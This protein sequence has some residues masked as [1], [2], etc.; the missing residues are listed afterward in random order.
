MWTLT[1]ERSTPPPTSASRLPEDAGERHSGGVWEDVSSSNAAVAALRPVG[2]VL[3]GGVS[4]RMGRDKATL[5]LP[6]SLLERWSLWSSG[7]WTPGAADALGQQTLTA[8][9]ARRLAVLCERVLVA[10]AQ[11]SG[12]AEDAV[13]AG[14]TAAGA[15]RVA[16]TLPRAAASDL[17]PGVERVADGP[18]RGPLAGI[19]GA[20]AAAPGRWLMVLACDLPLVRTTTLR[21]LIETSQRDPRGRSTVVWGNDRWQPLLA[22]YAPRDLDC[23]RRAAVR[24]DYALHRLLRSGAL[25]CHRYVISEPTPSTVPG[26]GP[27]SP[28]ELLNLNRPEDLVRLE[29]WLCRLG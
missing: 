9:A 25:D 17:P 4:T 23:L 8:W 7:G 20:A 22:L 29:E 10:G 1:C 6:P 27:D 21:D 28:A 2:V 16:S 13:D 12:A 11:R 5:E 15:H 3:A 18:G 19:L 24:G 26:A 14:G